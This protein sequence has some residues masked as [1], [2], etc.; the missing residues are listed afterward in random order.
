MNN[1]AKTNITK[2]IDTFLSQSK[3]IQQCAG[4]FYIMQKYHEVGEFF[5]LFLS[6]SRMTIVYGKVL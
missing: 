2:Y 1:C 4:R 3:I 5:A 6:K